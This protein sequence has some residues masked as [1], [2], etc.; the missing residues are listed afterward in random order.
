ME[1]NFHGQRLQDVQEAMFYQSGISLHSIEAKDDKH[2]VG[3]FTVAPDA[4]LGEHS[5]RLRSSHGVTEVKSFWVGQFPTVDEAEPNNGFDEV[6]RVELNTTVHGVAGNE[7][8]DYYVVTL[9]KGQ[10]LSVEIEAMR[11]GRLLFDSFVSVLD[12][13]RFEIASCDDVPLLR[14]DSFVSLLAPEDGDFRI[15][16]REAAYEGSDACQ[17]R[18]HI[19]TFPRPSA[20]HPVGGKPGETIEFSFIGDPSGPI[21]QSITLPADAVGPHPVFPEHDGLFAPSPHWVQ[22]SP[23]EHASETPDNRNQA[24]AAPFPAVPGAVHG[25][26]SEND[27]A[28]WF[29]FSAKK[30]QSFVIKALARQL[31]SPIDTVLSLHKGEGRLANNDDQGGPDSVVNWDCPEDGEYFIQVRDQL[32][33]SG[34]DFTYRIEITEKTPVIAANLPTVE[35]SQSQK[36]KVFPVPRGNRYA[37]VVNVT[38]ENASA[39]LLFQAAS[40]PPGVTMHCP[41]IPRA[42]NSI[43]VVFEATPDAVIG[44][45]L[46]PFNVRSTGDGPELHGPLVDTV[47]HIDVN[48]QGTYHS[49]SLDRIPVAVTTEAPYRIEVESPPVPLVKNGSMKV[50]VRAVR[51]EGFDNKITLRMLW[52]PPGVTGPVTVD[53]PEKENEALYELNANNDAAVADWS[54]CFLALADTPQ[55]PLVI[56]SSLVPLTVAEPYLTMALDLAAAEQGKPAPMLGKIE[57]LVDFE[58]EAIVEL[59]GLPHGVS[60]EPVKIKK[61]QAE[62]TFAL[63]L[64]DD[65]NVG[66]HQGIFCRIQVPANGSTVL[67]QTAHGG[68]LRI[69]APP[70]EPVVAKADAPQAEEKPAAAPTEKPLSRLEQLRQRAAN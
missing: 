43:P 11:L 21:N 50:K 58:G 40:L 10:R 55:G 66:K 4:A 19:G 63:T 46:H 22:V 68:T 49:V 48:N 3:K 56:S 44:G 36:W 69:D 18:L 6:Q 9:K 2:V 70:P 65:S 20:V 15:V 54:V 27:D 45:A 7:D 52:S 57:Q 14:T 29:K 28:D 47:H 51:Q 16:V 62:V 38:R 60:A 24:S 25:V 53:I 35:R 34:P 41:P 37:A 23:L 32:G 12:S 33:R 5:L 30:G 26:L 42:T 17:Y 1:V 31:R 64:A 39:D 59:T 67:H 8:E 13:K 61:D